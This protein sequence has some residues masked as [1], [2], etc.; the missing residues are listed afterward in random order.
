MNIVAFDG[1]LVS[2]S[3]ERWRHIILR[4]PQIGASKSLILEAVAQP[5]KVYVDVTGEIH[6]ETGQW[7]QVFW[8]SFTGLTVQA[9]QEPHTTQII[10]EKQGGTAYSES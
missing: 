8:W 5:D 1:T 2:L 4:H 10:R 6:F 7:N 3:E 9:M